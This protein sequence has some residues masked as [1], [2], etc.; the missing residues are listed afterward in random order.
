MSRAEKLP[1]DERLA[2]RDQER[3]ELRDRQMKDVGNWPV[4]NRKGQ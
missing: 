4:V 1:I 3:H 2:R